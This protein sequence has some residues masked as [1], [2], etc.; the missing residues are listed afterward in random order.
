[1]LSCPNLSRILGQF[2]KYCMGLMPSVRIQTSSASATKARFN[3][4]LI[5]TRPKCIER[6]PERDSECFKEGQGKAGAAV[7]GVRFP[8]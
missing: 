1:M 8:W 3:A 7:L 5:A 4:S 6:E 2:L